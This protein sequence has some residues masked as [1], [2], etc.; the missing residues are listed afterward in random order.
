LLHEA[1]LPTRASQRL[2]A[3]SPNPARGLSPDR[4]NLP[5]PEFHGQAA[6]EAATDLTNV[7]S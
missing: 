3:G 2:L 6:L 1:R 4:R 5:M 7:F